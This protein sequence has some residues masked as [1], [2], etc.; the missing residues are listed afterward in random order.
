MKTA[1]KAAGEKR[2]GKS[3][4]GKA[5]SGKR[6]A[7]MSYG[8][9]FTLIELLVVVAIMGIIMTICVPFMHNSFERRKGMNGAVRE[10]Q[11]ACRTARDWAILRQ[12][13]QELRIHPHD[14]VFEVGI[15]SAPAESDQ[16]QRLGSVDLH[17]DEWRIAD[18]RP[19]T[20]TATPK[21]G[22]GNFSARLPDGVIVE[23]LGVNGEDWTDDEVAR[24]Q[25]RRDGTSDEMSV[26]LYRAE[27]NERRNIWLEVV[28][29]LPELETDPSKFKV[30]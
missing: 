16:P 7:E 20:P 24:V 29:G 11:E 18:N 26:V 19:S 2:Q 30:R 13:T 3:G 28:T 14:G 25:F 15:S 4:R 8:G 21:A 17:G 12:T 1:R 5:E 23:G 10:V 6:K 22:G 27:T 9:G